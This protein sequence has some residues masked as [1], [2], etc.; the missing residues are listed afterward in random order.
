MIFVICIA[1]ATVSILATVA[2]FIYT[3]HE[4]QKRIDNESN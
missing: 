1:I 3:I 2:W 4:V